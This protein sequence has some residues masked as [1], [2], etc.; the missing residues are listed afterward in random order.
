MSSQIKVTHVIGGGEFGGAE[1][2]IIRLMERL[3]EYGVQGKVVCF[4][5]AG[6]SQALEEMGVE[7][8]VMQFG[9]FDMRLVSG[10]RRMFM[11]ERPDLIH[12]H[13]VKANFFARL[14]ARSLSDIP[15]VTTV[16]S[17]L[18]YDYL[19]RLAYV[20]ASLME[21]STWRWND[22]FIA[23]SSSIRQSLLDE[24]VQAEHVTVVHHGIDYTR[25]SDVQ[26]NLR[27]ELGLAQDTV[28]I[29]AVTRLVKI[30]AMD[31]LIRAMPRIIREQPKAHLVLVGS[32]PEEETLKSLAW[33]HG[34]ESHVHFT[35]FRRDIPA[36][37]R[38]FDIFVSAS[39]S[40]GLG[41]NVLEAMAAARPV[42]ATGV[43]GI[44]DLIEDH[45]NGL[46][47][48]TKMSGDLAD[49]II[50]LLRN[51]Q[52][53]RQLAETASRDVQERFSLDSMARNTVAV[54]RDVMASHADMHG[55]IAVAASEQTQQERAQQGR[56]N[57]SHE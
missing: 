14:A 8:E 57:A 33:T 17:L 54:Y 16:H 19:N 30:K 46:L 43:G 40:E 2:H 53:A 5:D 42:V 36:C 29:G 44:L 9:R 38:S 1:E 35:G 45:K 51:P 7:V 56:G 11:R 10:L 6:L 52:L 26:A 34:V 31:D 32:G 55:E 48:M 3:P 13:G 23:V 12:T 25:F 50:E 4:Y 37:M 24:G 41:L 39:L 15:L 49:A 27:D 22:H 47:A 28:V 18:R 21:K 20:G